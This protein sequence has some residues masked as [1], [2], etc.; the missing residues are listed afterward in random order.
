MAKDK[1]LS[2]WNH[3]VP[4]MTGEC[5]LTGVVAGSWFVGVGKESPDFADCV[6]EHTVFWIEFHNEGCQKMRY[7][8]PFS[9]TLAIQAIPDPK[10][11]ILEETAP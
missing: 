8:D 1:L 5:K 6:Y 3:I 7:K 9:S 10:P 11:P 4:R 2:P